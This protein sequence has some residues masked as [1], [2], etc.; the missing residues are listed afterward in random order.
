MLCPCLCS[1]PLRFWIQ[2][3]DFVKI[4]NQSKSFLQIFQRF[5]FRL[6]IFFRSEYL[7][8]T[9]Q[10]NLQVVQKFFSVKISR[11]SILRK[12]HS[13]SSLWHTEWH[14]VRNRKYTQ[15]NLAIMRS[16]VKFRPQK[17]TSSQKVLAAKNSCGALSVNHS[18]FRCNQRTVDDT[19]ALTNALCIAAA[20]RCKQT[21]FAR[22]STKEVDRR[23]LH[24]RPARKRIV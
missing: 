24:V 2:I 12:Y 22:R 8:P 17:F 19:I 11:K 13:K 23:L 1:T 4:L 16:Q 21:D 9:I 5:Y 7:S 14:K 10:K 3:F 20:N 6:K 15:F 18:Q